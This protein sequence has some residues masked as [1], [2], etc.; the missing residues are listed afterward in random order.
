MM[1]A[2]VLRAALLRRYN[3]VCGGGRGD[4]VGIATMC[5]LGAGWLPPARNPKRMGAGVLA[6]G[7]Y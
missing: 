4:V 6:Y 1:A 2:C 3:W 5:A 7:P